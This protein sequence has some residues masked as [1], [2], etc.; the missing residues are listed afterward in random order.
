[1]NSDAHFLI[2]LSRVQCT[3][4]LLYT[5]EKN[6]PRTIMRMMQ[7]TQ[8]TQNVFSLNHY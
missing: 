8:H 6:T 4:V 5:E 7:W 1:M 3:L 2:V